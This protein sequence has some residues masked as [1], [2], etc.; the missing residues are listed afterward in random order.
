MYTA[1]IDKK[2]Q[3][4]PVLVT[5]F[6]QYWVYFLPANENLN[7]DTS[8]SWHYLFLKKLHE[9]EWK[10][11]SITKNNFAINCFP[12]HIHTIKIKFRK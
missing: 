3:E 7:E 1:K 2:F 12:L 6:S 4:K 9:I 11:L 8:Q 10:V 5:A